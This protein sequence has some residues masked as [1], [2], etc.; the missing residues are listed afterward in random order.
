MGDSNSKTRRTTEVPRDHEKLL[1]SI[2]ANI[3]GVV[4]QL[5][6][7]ARGELGMHYVSE[8]A[9][10]ILGI[11]G[12]PANFV[13]AFTERLPP[14]EQTRFIKSIEESVK[15]VSPWIYEG[16][17]THPDGR[18]IFV[19]GMSTPSKTEDGLLF[20]GIILD[21]TEEKNV[22]K[23]RIEQEQILR[24]TTSNLP[25]VVFE[26]R[27]RRNAPQ[28]RRMHFVS[29]YSEEIFGLA[30]E[31]DSF[32]KRFAEHIPLEE[33]DEFEHSISQAIANKSA[34]HYEGSFQKHPRE[35]MTFSGAAVPSEQ[36]DWL[37]FHGLLLD[38]TQ[39]RRVE[40]ARKHSQK[41]DSLGQLAGGIAH[42][43]NNML[44]GIMGAAELLVERL[45]D[46]ENSHSLAQLI[47][48][49]SERAGKLTWQLLAFSR[50]AVHV[51]NPQSMHELI[52]R[53][54]Q[55]LE[56]S[57]DKR[58]RIQ[59]ALHADNELV[60]G[61]PSQL[62]AA[63]L[64]LGVNARDAMPEGGTLLFKTKNMTLTEAQDSREHPLKAGSYLE[65][66]IVDTGSGI[67]RQAQ[68]HIFEPFFTT[69]PTGKGT[70]MGLAAVYGTAAEHEGSIS[71]EET[72]PSGTVFRLLLPLCSEE[73]AQSIR[74][75]EKPR[76][77]ASARVLLIDDEQIVRHTARRL[78]ESL[79]YEVEVAEDG[80]AGVELFSRT[81]YDFNVIVL[82]MVM[83]RLNGED[84]F[85]QLR[86]ARPDIP[87][88]LCSGYSLDES[89]TRLREEGLAEHLTKPYRRRDLGESLRRA[90]KI[91]D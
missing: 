6:A 39:Q 1:Q 51:R 13:Q 4:Y 67:S 46:D 45:E 35:S 3:P 12:E 76:A 64:N 61:D 58:I 9:E 26:L 33:R 40:D 90:L 24:A 29:E 2:T 87:I 5:Y 23:Q 27:A 85:H 32:L 18:E 80:Q 82:D 50:K 48:D 41:L 53:T 14:S 11:S 22:E 91:A 65:V 31:A 71:L 52:E 37:V 30:S 70:G 66:L 16:P 60:M 62:Q 88:V 10:E 57:V 20:H 89:V 75:S 36:D 15:N 25:C 44:G 55:I 83:P 8:K 56:R 54:Q 77:K 84:A 38:H 69:K 34:W 78:I 59:C 73:E 43:F 79:G 28:E 42:D 81:P 7:S 86:A 49:T 68:S 47:L 21:I 74:G 19:R 72:S 63:L 17:F